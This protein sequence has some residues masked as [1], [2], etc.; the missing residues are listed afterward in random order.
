MDR[1]GSA[2]SD[3]EWEQP[4]ICFRQQ[5]F[6]QEWGSASCR[7]FVQVSISCMFHIRNSC[8]RH[9]KA[10]DEVRSRGE[11]SNT[12]LSM[13][14]LLLVA[15]RG[16]HLCIATGLWH[17]DGTS[18][19]AVTARYHSGTRVTYFPIID[20]WKRLIVVK[21][22]HGLWVVTGQTSAVLHALHKAQYALAK[23]CLIWLPQ[24]PVTPEGRA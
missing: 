5:T 20:P 18:V 11:I 12:L 24:A 14:C 6:P 4:C 22:A 23:W 10:M 16:V 8:D 13:G 19:V 21:I 3:H 17:V 2:G 15:I 1:N 7:N 9:K